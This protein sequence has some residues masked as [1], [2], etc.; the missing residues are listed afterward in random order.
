MRELRTTVGTFFPEWRLSIAWSVA[1]VLY[2]PRFSKGSDLK[3]QV[4]AKRRPSL[5]VEAAAC[6]GGR[7]QPEDSCSR[8]PTM[9]M[10]VVGATRPAA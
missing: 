4:V 9:L 5:A 3:P 8:Q 10:A 6:N 7:A 1:L 2:P